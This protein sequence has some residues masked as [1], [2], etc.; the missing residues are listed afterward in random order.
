MGGPEFGPVTREVI[1]D[2]LPRLRPIDRLE[3]DC[4]TQGD[5]AVAVERM[6]GG[7]RR[8]CAAYMGGDLVCIMGVSAPSLMSPVGCPWMLTTRAVERPYVRRAFVAGSKASLEWVSMDF[9]RLW[10]LVA[11]E[12]TVAVRWLRWMGFRFSG[13]DVW[14]QGHQF[15]HFEMEIG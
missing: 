2:L 15:L 5:R 9:Q 1:V 7:A 12:N 14:L 13:R 4:M 11:A 3:L 8:A 6:V 10:N